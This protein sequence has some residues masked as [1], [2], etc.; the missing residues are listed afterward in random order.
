MKQYGV[1]V[2]YILTGFNVQRAQIPAPPSTGA[3]QYYQGH[4]G[5]KYFMRRFRL[6]T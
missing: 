2:A 3:P 4:Q 6:V 1:Q 5:V